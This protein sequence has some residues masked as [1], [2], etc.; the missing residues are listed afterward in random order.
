M[1]EEIER[2]Q[3][4][5]SVHTGFPNPATDTSLRSLDL[6]KLLI[7]HSASTYFFRVR[8]SEWEKAGV[9]DGDIAIVDRALGPRK[10]DTVVWWDQ[11]Q[12]SFAISTYRNMPADAT[13]WGVITA[14]IHE[15]RKASNG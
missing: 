1:G 3:Q 8:G 11:H 6:N 9:F 15:F 7:S 5:I 4:G 14:T 2:D 10:A 12:D 13:L